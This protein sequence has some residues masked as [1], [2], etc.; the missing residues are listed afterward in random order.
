MPR[1]LVIDEVHVSLS[2]SSRIDAR[3]CESIRRALQSRRFQRSLR[4]AVRAIL[5]RFP[6]LRKLRLRISR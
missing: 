1:Y 4:F 5:V 2:V 3:Q 6:P